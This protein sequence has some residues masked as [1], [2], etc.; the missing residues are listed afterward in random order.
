MIDLGFLDDADVYPAGDV[1][2]GAERIAAKLADIAA[3][4]DKAADVQQRV[5]DD[6][7]LPRVTQPLVDAIDRATTPQQPQI[8]LVAA[9]FRAT[10]HL[11][12]ERDAWSARARS[13]EAERLAWV[14]RARVAEEELSAITASRTWRATRTLSR[15]LAAVRRARHG[16]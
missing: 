13:A 14:E 6:L 7:T 4:H 11:A 2:A 5:L 10:D 3:A 8:Q 9:L 15:A 1:E 16:H 12:V